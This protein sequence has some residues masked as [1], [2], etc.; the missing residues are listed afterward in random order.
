MKSIALCFFLFSGLGGAS[1]DLIPYNKNGNWGVVDKNKNTIIPFLFTNIETCDIWSMKLVLAE[2]PDSLYV[3]N[4]I[5]ELLLKKEHR[6][7][8]FQRRLNL[9]RNCQGFSGVYLKGKPHLIVNS[10][11]KYQVIS[12]TGGV[13]IPESTYDEILGA[14]NSLLVKQGKK[15]GVIDSNLRMVLP[16]DY[17]KISFS[18]D[19]AL[20]HTSEKN[21]T[22]YSRK[23][24]QPVK[25]E[26][27]PDHLY[28]TYK[29]SFLI[30]EKGKKQG[31]KD[32]L[33]NVLIPAT[34]ERF[35]FREKLIYAQR[36]DKK[37]DVYTKEAG[38][39]RKGIERHSDYKD[40][41]LLFTGNQTEVLDTNLRLISVLP[42]KDIFLSNDPQYNGQHWSFRNANTVPKGRY[43]AYRN[44]SSAVININGEI[45]FPLING[46][47]GALFDDYAVVDFDIPGYREKFSLKEKD[48]ISIVYRDGKKKT[49]TVNGSVY[50]L[51]VH[52]RLAFLKDGK[53]GFVNFDGEVVIPAL[54]ERDQS[55]MTYSIEKWDRFT[56]FINRK[57]V[58]EVKLK[59]RRVMIDTLGNIL[60][61]T[62]E[63]EGLDYISLPNGFMIVMYH[64]EKPS[65]GLRDTMNT[66]VLRAEKIYQVD[67][68]HFAAAKDGKHALFNLGLTQLTPYQYD[69][70][71][72]DY[73]F[74]LLKVSK[75]GKTG[76]LNNELKEFFE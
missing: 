8:T 1:Q 58:A 52:N 70:I 30:Y 69:W 13:V 28:S 39:F 43:Y 41:I 12:G 38:F 61:D 4:T 32:S 26:I 73:S 49:I 62:T 46:K 21:Y 19:Y 11:G 40:Y 44:D 3:F 48:S 27:S 68:D 63:P 53:V 57:A 47:Y 56:S 42:Y 71:M 16:I 45:V 50:G 22:T 20:A 24:W 59:T 51:P 66:I 67:A 23:T 2:K 72:R 34:Y 64:G 54:F 37:F 35:E 36:A 76:Y 29:Y 14:G 33:C 15:Y 7:D 55:I 17:P 25:C 31:L 65:F 18:R 6:Y 60:T 9:T 10:N 5:G 75:N 74:G